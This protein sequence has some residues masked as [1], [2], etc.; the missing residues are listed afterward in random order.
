MYEFKKNRKIREFVRIFKHGS[1]ECSIYGTYR[2][3]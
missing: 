1:H 2:S 3:V